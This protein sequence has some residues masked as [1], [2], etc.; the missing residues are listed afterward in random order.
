MKNCLACPFNDGLTEEACQAQN[1]GCLPTKQE[2]VNTFDKTGK[3]LSCHE[4]GSKPCRGLMTVREIDINRIL[5]YS[6]WYR[7]GVK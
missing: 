2:M 4:D 7:S 5:E 1:Y 3:S 6:D